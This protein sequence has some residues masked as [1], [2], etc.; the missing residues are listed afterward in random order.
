VVPLGDYQRYDLVIDD[1]GVFS[2]VQCKLGKLTSDKGAIYFHPCS[3]D[4]RSQK[5]RCI[6]KG[7]RG[8]VEFFGVYC[9]ELDKKYLVPVADAASTCC[10]L[11]LTPPKNGPKKGIRWAVDYEILPNR[12]N[13]RK[14]ANRRK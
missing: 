9:E 1:D 2:R 13:G 5:G 11:R 4:S 3:I 8:Q 10:Y 14:D 12:S 7:Y 6:R